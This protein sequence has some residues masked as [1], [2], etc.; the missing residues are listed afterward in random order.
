MN[1]TLS[2]LVLFFGRFHPVL[3][4]LPIGGLVLLAVLE[5]TSRFPRF[6]D[7]ARNRRLILGFT[8]AASVI[9]ASCGWLLSSSGDYD[10][11]L[12]QWHKWAGVGFVLACA[13]TFLVCRAQPRRAYR[14]LLLVALILLMVAGHL[15]ASITHG[16]DFLTR[17]APIL[18]RVALASRTSSSASEPAA[19]QEGRWPVYAEV[20]EPIFQRRCIACH[21]PERHKANLRL[22]SYEGL[23][24]GG[25]NGPVFVAGNPLESLLIKRLTL[26]LEDEDH[27]PPASQ[28]QL[29]AQEV[30]L[31]KLWIDARAP[32]Q[33]STVSLQAHRALLGRDTGVSGDS[34]RNAAERGN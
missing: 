7:A 6:Q 12:L 9:A 30:A 4:H 24:R 13:L 32:T 14:P 2:N 5:L 29:T 23:C 22:D 8:A 26:P 25:E 15:G 27:M 34:A 16:R 21:G 10:R 17:Y 11:Q 18:W 19:S 28:P 20:I 31:L 1:G 33:I 3:V